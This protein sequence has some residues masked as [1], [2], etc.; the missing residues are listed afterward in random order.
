MR[1]IGNIIEQHGVSRMPIF[2]YSVRIL[3][4]YGDLPIISIEGAQFSD[5]CPVCKRK[6][7]VGYLRTQEENLDKD[8]DIIV[9]NCLDCGCMYSTKGDNHRK[10]ALAIEE[11]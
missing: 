4:Y 10:Y 1:I 3:Q 7:E 6:T 8:Y 9:V 2:G 11:S 5:D